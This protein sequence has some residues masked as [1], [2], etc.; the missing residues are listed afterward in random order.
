M[1]EVETQPETTVS[2][3]M[4]IRDDKVYFDFDFDFEAVMSYEFFGRRIDEWTYSDMC[5][6]VK[7]NATKAGTSTIAD[8]A[9]EHIVPSYENDEVGWNATINE[10]KAEDKYVDI[11]FD[12]YYVIVREDGMIFSLFHRDV[13]LQTDIPCGFGQ[14]WNEYF[15]KFPEEFVTYMHGEYVEKTKEKW[16]KK[17]AEEGKEIPTSQWVLF[18]SD[19]E[20][21]NGVCQP[22][23]TI[24]GEECFLSDIQF[25]APAGQ[26][27]I[28]IH[29][30]TDVIDWVVISYK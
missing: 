13:P 27:R 1:E 29:H 10:Y 24:D 7:A 22:G 17:Y 18:N 26:Y 21:K 12:G 8:S 19:V 14:E 6:Y 16:Y 23:V 15:K 3:I 30:E 5:E 4:Q 28:Q 25:V 11:H 2:S 20:I 9:G